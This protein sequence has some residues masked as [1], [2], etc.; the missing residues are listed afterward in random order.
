MLARIW[1]RSVYDSPK[2]D[3]QVQEPHAQEEV[4]A[5]EPSTDLAVDQE[6]LVVSPKTAQEMN[7]ELP[8]RST[9]DASII[10]NEMALNGVSTSSPTP[11]VPGKRKRQEVDVVDEPPRKRVPQKTEATANGE[12]HPTTTTN[13]IVTGHPRRSNRASSEVVQVTPGKLRRPK[14]KQIRHMIQ[15]YP[16]VDKS[17]DLYEYPTSPRKQTGNTDA[18]APT[19]AKE[20]ADPERTP[21]RRGRPPRVGPPPVKKTTSKEQ[22]QPQDPKVKLRRNGRSER[23]AKPQV[24]NT[25]QQ[26]RPSTST[27]SH[28]PKPGDE[29]EERLRESKFTRS[30]AVDN[31]S[32]NVVTNSDREMTKKPVHNARRAAEPPE[33]VEVADGD[34]GE[35]EEELEEEAAREGSEHFERSADED[36]QRSTHGEAEGGTEDEEAGSDV[37]GSDQVSESEDDDFELFGQH[38]AWTNV[39]EG[40]RSVCGSKLPLNQ[41]PKLFTDPMKDLVLEVKGARECYEEI[42]SLQENDDNELHIELDGQLKDKLDAI[43]GQIKSLSKNTAAKNDPKMIRDI[44]AR[45][46]P[47]LVFLLRSALASRL[48]YRSEPCD[49]DSLDESVNSLEE[50]VGLQKTT[51]LLCKNAR[52]WKVKPVRTEKPIVRPTSQLILPHLS[53]MYKKFSKILVEEQK[54]RKSKRNAA[55]YRKRQE[56]IAESSERAKQEAARKSELTLRKLRESREQEDVRRRNEKRTLAQIKELEALA[57]MGSHPVSDHVEA[58][59]TW[60]DAEDLELY[61]QLEKGYSGDLT[62]TSMKSDFWWHCCSLIFLCS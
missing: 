13:G 58:R 30:T 28:K 59:P 26:A 24:E 46:I 20:I 52:A 21:R 51:L 2:D 34:D 60:S 12:E 45:V 18:T 39:L 50:I 15:V 41:M 56:E 31:G 5:P 55:Q 27:K 43:A 10:A 49:L 22:G 23:E 54:R 6:V 61:F 29:H 4:D 47:A 38:R 33:S 8:D 57:R 16:A 1:R 40:A 25:T 36:R 37:E 42:L 9:E 53:I 35:Q 7:S 44:Y 14:K 3:P 62:C 48:Y 32:K 17:G 19:T 11:S